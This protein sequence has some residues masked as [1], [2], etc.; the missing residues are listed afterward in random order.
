M[1]DQFLKVLQQPPDQI[2]ELITVAQGTLQVEATTVGGGGGSGV[3]LTRAMFVDPA[4][5]LDP[6]DQTGAATAPFSTIAAAIAALPSPGGGVVL[7][8]PAQ[9]PGETLD[10]S[11]RPVT[12][13]GLAGSQ[14]DPASAAAIVDC[15]GCN[16]SSNAPVN[17]VNVQ[18][19]GVDLTIVPETPQP[20]QC[21][22]C[23]LTGG[24]FFESGRLA[25]SVSLDLLASGPVVLDNTTING[26]VVCAGEPTWH[27]STVNGNVTCEDLTA[28]DCTINGTVTNATI[29]DPLVFD[30]CA[31]NSINSFASVK[32]LN[33]SEV[34]GLL[35]AAGL[36]IRDSLANG[37]TI[38][39]Q[40]NASDST[41]AAGVTCQAVQLAADTRFDTVTMTLGGT[42][43]FRGCTYNTLTGTAGANVQ[44]DGYS[45]ASGPPASFTSVT[46]LA[47]FADLVVNV[48]TLG[49]NAIGSVAVST[50]GTGLDGLATGDRISAQEPAA[51][52][53]GGGALLSWRISAADQITFN[54][55]GTTTGGNQTFRVVRI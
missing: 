36:T 29:F 42:S 51:G 41:F 21:D 53:T 50:V 48:P 7:L 23:T 39:G 2:F 25:N 33:G 49:A 31:I 16:I 30:H 54:F 17:L 6:G 34:T 4:T 19:G 12:I 52:T 32:L 35:S 3:P 37:A 38:D 44:L 20:F 43:T 1:A 26:D 55:L 15:Q 22:G 45:L 46:L 40:L 13:I 14:K 5:T 28:F 24:M 8:T 47:Q 18:W 10:S 9:Y 11:D 27:N